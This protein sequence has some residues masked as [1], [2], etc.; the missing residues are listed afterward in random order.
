MSMSE[1]VAEE[2]KKCIAYFHG[3]DIYAKK[4]QKKIHKKA[5]LTRAILINTAIIVISILIIWIFVILKG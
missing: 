3:K 4:F 5:N 2:R 1:S